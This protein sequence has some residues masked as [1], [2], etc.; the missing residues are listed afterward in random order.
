MSTAAFTPGQEAGLR[1]II[2]EERDAWKRTLPGLDISYP[3]GVRRKAVRNG[4]R[5]LRA[6]AL[7]SAVTLAMLLW[8]RS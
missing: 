2:R 7:A 8:R 4:R 5:M 6:G 1:E 3:V